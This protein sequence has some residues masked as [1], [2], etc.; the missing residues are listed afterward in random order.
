VAHG[1]DAAVVRVLEGAVAAMVELR[2]PAWLDLADAPPDIASAYLGTPIDAADAGPQPDPLSARLAVTPTALTVDRA[3]LT[4]L[5]ILVGHVPDDARCAAF[6]AT[7][8]VP[9]LSATPAGGAFPAVVTLTIDPRRLP[10]GDATGTLT[11][12]SDDST[13]SDSPQRVTV[14]VTGE[15][16]NE[17]PGRAYMPYAVRL[18]GR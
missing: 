10:S 2:R 14:T 12:A 5:Q 8:D 15:P 6:T 3:A 9:W 1:A 4:P 16:V 13:I 17:D 18:A 11:I 7:A